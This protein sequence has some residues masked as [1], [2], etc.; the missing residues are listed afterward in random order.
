MLEIALTGC[1]YSGKTGVAKIF[2]QLQV[3]VFDSDV[4]LKFLINFKPEVQSAIY[5]NIGSYLFSNGKLDKS[6]FV[7]TSLFDRTIDIVEFE[8]FK[9]YENFK[10]KH[11]DTPYVIFESSILFERSWQTK[12]TKVI[13]VFTPKE[14]RVRRAR[15]LTGKR[16]DHLWTLADTETSDLLKNN[17]SNWIIHNYFDGPDTLNQVRQID[18]EII[19]LYID[20]QKTKPTEIK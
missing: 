6:C 11:A 4:I 7:T 13:S 8:L 2:K 17:K 20:F 19:D 10:Q 14:E 15:E 18:D 1:R 3:P 12:F 5:Q 16:I 9:S